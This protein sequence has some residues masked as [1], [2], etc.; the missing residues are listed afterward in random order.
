MVAI[1]EQWNSTK[2]NNYD[3][4]ELEDTHTTTGKINTSIHI[5]HNLLYTVNTSS[6]A[7]AIHVW[8]KVQ[9]IHIIHAYCRPAPENCNPTLI[10]YLLNELM[11][12][13]QDSSIIATGDWNRNEEV[14]SL[15]KSFGL[16]EVAKPASHKKS[17]TGL[18]ADLQKV[19]SNR[20]DCSAATV[21]E[22][23]VLS[24]HALVSIS[25]PIISKESK[26]TY[27]PNLIT[28]EKVAS[29]IVEGYS[30]SNIYEELIS[31]RKATRSRVKIQSNKPHTYM[32]ELLNILNNSTN[33]DEAAASYNQR[34]EDFSQQI[35]STITHTNDRS[36]WTKLKQCLKLKPDNGI[37]SS[38]KLDN[39]SVLYGNDA[40][41]EIIGV[42]KHIHEGINTGRTPQADFEDLKPI[43][44][45]I[46]LWCTQL[47]RNKSPSWDCIPDYAFKLDCRDIES[48]CVTC[49]HK[50]DRAA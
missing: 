43:T 31:N 33:P 36:S 6:E 44:H 17:F 29:K 23:F 45:D 39:G 12:C 30:W 24:D 3:A 27:R 22:T 10:E 2:L 18:P 14:E 11:D 5:R 9:D 49:K 35:T 7:N 13:S 34:F 21:D 19:Y 46:H 26:R 25:I 16:K 38:I 47:A 28:A 20:L 40:Q 4:F 32:N 41:R 1:N 15:L 50:L 8:L 42:F 37:A 48:L